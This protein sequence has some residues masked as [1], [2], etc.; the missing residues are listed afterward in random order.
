MLKDA[1]KW[2]TLQYFSLGLRSICTVKVAKKFH[3]DSESK[4]SGQASMVNQG[5]A[6]FHRCVICSLWLWLC[7][8]IGKIKALELASSIKCT[9][10]FFVQFCTVIKISLFTNLQTLGSSLETLIAG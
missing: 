9:E 1:V 5:A 3:S 10:I 6:L 2:A 7:S 8:E 4:G